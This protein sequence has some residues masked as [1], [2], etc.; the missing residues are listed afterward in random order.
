[1]SL[2]SDIELK[3]LELKT[4]G[5]VPETLSEGPKGNNNFQTHFLKTED[6]F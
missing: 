1:M 2:K 4:Y 5:T 3:T 6:I